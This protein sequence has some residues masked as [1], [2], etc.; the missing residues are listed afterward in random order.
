MT[1]REVLTSQHLNQ[2]TANNFSPP[3]QYKKSPFFQTTTHQMFDEKVSD[4][5]YPQSPV[6]PIN[7]ELNKYTKVAVS[8]KNADGPERR[9]SLMHDNFD[10]S[11]DLSPVKRKLPMNRNRGN[12]NID[13]L[14]P[15]Y[16]KVMTS[17]HMFFSPKKYEP[18]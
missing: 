1:P 11:F 5:R 18:K 17:R 12:F 10:A 15:H 16:D 14:A 2:T 8:T 13:T 9:R 7:H 3:R 6:S 4:Y